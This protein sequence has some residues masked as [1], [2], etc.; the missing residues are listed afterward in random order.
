MFSMT[1]FLIKVAQIFREVLGSFENS[2]FKVKTT[3]DNFVGYYGNFGLL[4]TP[5]SD[6]TGG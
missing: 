5:T 3:I 1:N 2:T 4:F 6:H